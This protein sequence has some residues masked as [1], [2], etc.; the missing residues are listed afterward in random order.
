MWVWDERPMKISDFRKATQA[1]GFVVLNLGFTSA[2]KTGIVCPALFCY[3]CPLAM[4]ACPFGTLQH[5]VAL[6]I[7]PLYA[8]GTVGLFSA[9][10]GRAYCGWFCPF[11]TVQDVVSSLSGKKHKLR[12]IPWTKFVVLAVALIAAYVTAETLFCRFCPS[13]S[14]FGA[15]PYVFLGGVSPLPFGVW[16]HVVTLLIV[17]V[18]VLFVERI[19]CRYLCPVGAIF[20][21]FNRV[22]ALRMEVDQSLCTD[23]RQCLKACP[24]GIM[25]KSAIGGSTDCSRCGKCIEACNKKAIR[26]TLV[27]S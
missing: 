26:F 18:G 3:A 25:D 11:G 7:V 2:L 15:L 4:F 13:G 14:L 27:H 23:C 8:G 19:W 17:V 1:L 16:V 10:L 20:G 5:F 12:T 9:L 24:M 21:S 22:S 6:A